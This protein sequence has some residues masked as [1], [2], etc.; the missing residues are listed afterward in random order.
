MGGRR[1][2]PGGGGGVGGAGGP[3]GCEQFAAPAPRAGWISTLLLEWLQKQCD[4]PVQGF[5]PPSSMLLLE[6]LRKQCNHP[7]HRFL[8]TSRMSQHVGIE[9][10]T[11][12][13]QPP[14]PEG[15]TR[16]G[17]Y[18]CDASLVRGW[19][20]APPGVPSQTSARSCHFP[21]TP[22][23][24]LLKHHQN[25][26]GECAAERQS[27]RRVGVPLEGAAVLR[28]DQDPGSAGGLLRAAVLAPAPQAGWISRLLLAWL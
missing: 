18:P 7:P 4:H 21:D 11:E 25:R 3:C 1:H 20:D 12:A 13:V 16:S 15:R 19:V 26:E 14:G 28:P 24:S 17:L 10:T 8:P 23:P 6:W 27:R 2:V 5:L 22:Y 9:M